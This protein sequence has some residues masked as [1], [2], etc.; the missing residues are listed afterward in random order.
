MPDPEAA[1]GSRADLINRGEICRKCEKILDEP[2][3][4][5]ATCRSCTDWHTDS[6]PAEDLPGQTFMF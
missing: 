4:E 1:F 2:A 3:G 6:A 5:P